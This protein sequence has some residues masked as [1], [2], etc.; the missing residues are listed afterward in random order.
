MERTVLIQ[1]VRETLLNL[2]EAGSGVPCPPTV[3]LETDKLQYLGITLD[4]AAA[5]TSAIQ[6]RLGLPVNF[7]FMLSHQAAA[8]SVSGS[9]SSYTTLAHLIDHV[10]SSLVFHTSQARK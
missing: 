10:T 6:E 2:S 5:F 9:N 4:S 7:Q 3:L 8:A 1:I